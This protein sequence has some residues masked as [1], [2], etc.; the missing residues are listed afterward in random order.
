MSVVVVVV[1]VVVVIIIIIIIIKVWF[2]LFCTGAHCVLII[3]TSHLLLT[4]PGK[5]PS[6]LQI[7]CQITYL[8]IPFVTDSF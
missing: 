3:S 1:V 4:T 5:G 7:S 2:C 8:C 6:S